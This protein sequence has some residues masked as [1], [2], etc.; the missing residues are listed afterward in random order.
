MRRW[1]DQRIATPYQLA[2]M[3]LAE[4]ASYL[5]HHLAL[6]GECPRLIPDAVTVECAYV[7]LRRHCTEGDRRGSAA[8]KAAP[9]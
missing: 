5:R 8:P 4:S 3:D 1:V 2:P 9:E 6:V 7:N